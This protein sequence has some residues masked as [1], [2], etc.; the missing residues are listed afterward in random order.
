MPNEM[1]A[2]EMEFGKRDI[3]STTRKHHQNAQRESTL[4]KPNW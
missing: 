1:H 3:E 2:R 4:R